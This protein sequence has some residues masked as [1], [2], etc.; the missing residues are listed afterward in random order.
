[1]PWNQIA[2][3]GT[4]EVALR[5][6]RAPKNK[7]SLAIA[8]GTRAF[9]IVIALRAPIAAITKA[10]E[11]ICAPYDENVC[12]ALAATGSASRYAVEFDVITS[13]NGRA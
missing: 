1:M 12:A 11:T 9:I 4:R 2:F 6:P 7:P 13:P 8:N 3:T 10:I 5:L